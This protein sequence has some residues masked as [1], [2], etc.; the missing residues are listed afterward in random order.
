MHGS[1][2]LGFVKRNAVALLVVGLVVGAASLA[3]AA[4]GSVGGAPAVGSLRAD[5]VR[6]PEHVASLS[7]DGYSWQ[8]DRMVAVWYS[9]P[10]TNRFVR[11]TATASADGVPT[12]EVFSLGLSASDLSDVSGAVA[13]ITAQAQS[14]D[15]RE[16]IQLAAPEFEERPTPSMSIKGPDPSRDSVR[17]IPTISPRVRVEGVLIDGR[18]PVLCAGPADLPAGMCTTMLS[19]SQ[20]GPVWAFGSSTLGSLLVTAADVASAR[21]IVG[22]ERIPL[23]RVAIDAEWNGAVWGTTSPAAHQGD[24]AVE[25]THQD[26]RT[27]RSALN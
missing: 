12:Y 16:G 6:F 18:E 3:A 8:S 24:A 10:A 20:R 17:P 5:L 22:T 1:Q 13:R 14:G 11:V 15:Q 19:S 21:L 27:E 7:P 25:L 4:A 2:R 9:D 26:G 23:T